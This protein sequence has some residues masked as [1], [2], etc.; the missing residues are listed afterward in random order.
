MD[1]LKPVPFKDKASLKVQGFFGAS[2]KK[3]NAGFSTSA[4]PAVEM[5]R[6]W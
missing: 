3:H 1:G 2:E 6:L 5:T 4:A